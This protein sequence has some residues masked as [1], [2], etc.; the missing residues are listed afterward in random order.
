MRSYAAYLDD[1]GGKN[2][3]ILFA[4]SKRAMDMQIAEAVSKHGA[5]CLVTLYTHYCVAHKDGTMDSFLTTSRK[6]TV[7]A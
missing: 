6:Y 4:R 3:D 5:L 1:S 7:S 2:V